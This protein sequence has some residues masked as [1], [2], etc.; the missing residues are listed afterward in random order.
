MLSGTLLFYMMD[1]HDIKQHMVG[2]VIEVVEP[3]F[4]P[5]R[6]HRLK[7]STNYFALLSVR[8]GSDGAVTPCFVRNANGAP[9]TI[10]TTR[11]T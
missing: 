11:A 3:V 2:A 4:F 5:F 10:M 9:M 8:V 6:F 7:P 1:M